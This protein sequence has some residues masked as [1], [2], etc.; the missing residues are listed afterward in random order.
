MPYVSR[1]FP[2]KDTRDDHHGVSS[3]LPETLTRSHKVGCTENGGATAS[4]AALRRQA[5]A[6]IPLG[7]SPRMEI[8]RSEWISAA[9]RTQETLPLTPF[10]AF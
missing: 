9:M 8:F 10:I 2:K 3:N 5:L 1:A 7:T 6:C 4:R